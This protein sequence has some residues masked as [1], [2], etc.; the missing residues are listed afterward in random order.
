MRCR[1]CPAAFSSFSNSSSRRTMEAM[2]LQGG[3]LQR[4][5]NAS[6]WRENPSISPA[7][8]NWTEA[9]CCDDVG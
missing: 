4:W 6:S 3:S 7:L 2:R 5:R 8:A 9:G 1:S